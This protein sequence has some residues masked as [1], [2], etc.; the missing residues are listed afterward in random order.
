MRKYN[1]E[2]VRIAQDV[3]TGP[4][5]IP[6]ATQAGRGG[7]GNLQAARKREMVRRQSMTIEGR[8][9]TSTDSNNSLS[10]VNSRASSSSSASDIGV[11]AWSKNLLF[12][13]RNSTNTKA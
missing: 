6:H 5:R 9:R 12:G 4:S 11:A 8:D 1:L 10:T 3:P 13:R 7:V 2:E